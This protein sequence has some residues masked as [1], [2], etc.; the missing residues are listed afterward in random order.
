M[1]K[2]ATRH[3]NEGGPLAYDTLQMHMRSTGS[4]TENKEYI[5]FDGYWHRLEATVK[6]IEFTGWRC[7]TKVVSQR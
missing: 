3:T 4:G 2:Y 5:V 6:G 1:L 7:G